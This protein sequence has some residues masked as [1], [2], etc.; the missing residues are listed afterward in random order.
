[1]FE[2][3]PSAILQ[4]ERVTYA[5]C[6]VFRAAHSDV[7]KK[8]SRQ[9]RCQYLRVARLDPTLGHELDRRGLAFRWIR[10]VAHA[11]GAAAQRERLNELA[12]RYG[13]APLSTPSV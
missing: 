2:S 3:R 5:W 9:A 12:R 8:V 4:R 6:C 1:M 13:W 10:W 11:Q 7:R